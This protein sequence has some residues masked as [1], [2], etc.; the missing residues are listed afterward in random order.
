[1]AARIRLFLALTIGLE[2]PPTVLAGASEV[3]E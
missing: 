3:I 1:M 2:V